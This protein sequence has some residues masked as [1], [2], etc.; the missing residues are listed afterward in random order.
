MEEVL[1]C[2]VEP[3]TVTFLL[4]FYPRIIGRKKYWHV[5][6]MRPTPHPFEWDLNELA[7]RSRHLS[8]GKMQTRKAKLT[9]FKP[10]MCDQ[11]PEGWATDFTKSIV[12]K[13]QGQNPQQLNVCFLAAIIV[14]WYLALVEL[15]V[16]CSGISTDIYWT[17]MWRYM[18]CPFVIAPCFHVLKQA[19]HKCLTYGCAMP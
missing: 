8:S 16:S 5:Q 1:P 2:S 13:W 17:L 9:A 12:Q 15:T 19:H 7:T 6:F 11:Q 3:I 4:F 18:C 10:A 14:H